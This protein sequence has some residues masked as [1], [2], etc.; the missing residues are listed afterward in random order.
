MPNRKES[1][2]LREI[3]TR[4]FL[5]LA[6]INLAMFFGFQMTNVGLPVYVAQLGANAQIVGLVGT[7]MTITA[8]VVRIFAGPLLDRF[9]RK[10]ALVGGSVVMAASIFSYAV[11]PLVGIILGVRLLQG[12]GWGLGS[13]ASS[14]M[15]ADVIPKRRFAEGMGYFALTNAL[16][17]ALAPAVS[18]A[19]V[20]GPGAHYMIY[21]A[22]GCTALA[23]V[24]ALFQR[25]TAK[26]A[27]ISPGAP[28]NASEAG[29][30]TM[31]EHTAPEPNAAPNEQAAQEHMPAPESVGQPDTAPAGS[32]GTARPP[33]ST[34]ASV[35]DAVFERRALFPGVLMLLVNIGFGC[36]TTF[37]ALHGQ[38]QG[39]AN[40]SIY[41]IAYAVVTLASRPMIGRLIDRYGYRMPSILSCLGTV[42][43]LA[44]IGLANSTLMFACAGTLAGI[45]IGTAMGVFQAMAVASVEPWRRGVATSTYFIAFDIG[46]AAGSLL[47]G[48]VAGAFGYTVMYF[49]VAAF[50]LLAG[51]LSAAMVRN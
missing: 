5:L 22:A 45:G 30:Q 31:S 14:T 39:V 42:L 20:Q 33:A 28:A 37:I 15:A 24:L 46:I 13:T 40:V 48:F 23:F 16:S 43:T 36:I 3:F 2:S 27:E 12:V 1:A 6:T 19:L 49:A 26:R 9:G 38:E 21:V 44:L 4:D 47:G 51:I 8:V 10:G 50:P 34:L 29:K 35:L 17:S 32:V 25:N 18:I 41:F 11:F 7:V